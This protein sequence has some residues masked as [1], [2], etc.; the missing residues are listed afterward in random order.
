MK[1]SNFKKRVTKNKRKKSNRTR[2]II[3][4]ENEYNEMTSF[5]CSFSIDG[6]T[7]EI[8]S[9][10]EKNELL[11]E[12]SK[13]TKF[14]DKYAIDIIKVCFKT[15]QDN[16]SY[17]FIIIKL[18]PNNIL[19]EQIQNILS[20][21]K[22]TDGNYKIFRA[23]SKEVVVQQFW[24][25]YGKCYEDGSLVDDCNIRDLDMESIITRL[26]QIME[27]GGDYKNV[28]TNRFYKN[29]NDLM[30]EKQSDMATSEGIQTYNGRL[31]RRSWFLEF[32]EKIIDMRK[33]DLD[34]YLENHEDKAFLFSS[35]F[36]KIYELFI[37]LLRFYCYGGNGFRSGPS[38]YKKSRNDVKNLE[39]YFNSQYTVILSDIDSLDTTP[40]QK[41]LLKD[42]FSRMKEN[43]CTKKK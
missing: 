35:N 37:E 20:R 1:K 39:K 28:P 29:I 14:L 10:K 41:Q 12:L 24:K 11:N 18:D 2:K 5:E 38:P 17:N 4:G 3:G 42:A 9:E 40:E 15:I 33:T 26:E 36:Y 27:N 30:L 43:R 32:R 16:L 34:K 6:T 7:V 23:D 22:Q 25:N 31:S 8:I 19:L 13:M 21:F